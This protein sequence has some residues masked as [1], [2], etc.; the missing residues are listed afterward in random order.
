MFR[1]GLILLVHLEIA[2]CYDDIR[3]M[4][5]A[6]DLSVSTSQAELVQGHR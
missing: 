1:R 6:F 5:R 3:Q 2:P 4:G